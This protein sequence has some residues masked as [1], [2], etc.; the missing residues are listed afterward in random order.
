MKK[1]II[2]TV[3][4]LL[5]VPGFAGRKEFLQQKARELLALNRVVLENVKGVDQVKDGDVY[6]RAK[7]I[8][9]D[10]KKLILAVEEVSVDQKKLKV[11]KPEKTV[12]LKGKI[13]KKPDKKFKLDLEYVLPKKKSD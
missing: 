13:A 4:L 7:I 11:D 8:Q 12:F 2:V 3:V 10:D 9:R 5:G 1:I 6:V